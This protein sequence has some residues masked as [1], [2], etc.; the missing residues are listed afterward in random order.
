MASIVFVQREMEDKLGPMALAGYV[1]AFGH[2]ASI[3]VYPLK[4]LKRL[5]ELNP[6]LVG[7]SILSPSIDWAIATAQAIKRVLPKTPIVIGGPHPTFYPEVLQL[8]GLDIA[9]IGEGE[10]PL[11]QLLSNFDGTMESVLHT[12]NCWVKSGTTITKNEMTNLLNEEE[13][14]LLPPCD[15]SHYANYNL[16]ANN[17]HKK[18]WATRGCPLK[19][20][21]CFNSRYNAIYKGMG[22]TVR[23]RSVECIM[24]ELKQLK[25]YGWRCLEIVDDQFLLN[26]QWL[27]RFCQEYKRHI[28]LPFACN[29]TATQVKED[30]IRALK[31]AGCRTICF[32]VE[33]GSELIRRNVYSKPVTDADIYQAG[34]ILHRHRMPFLTFNMVGLPE[35]TMRDMYSTVEINQKL[36]TP[37]PWCS[38]VQPYPGTDLAD[39]LTRQGVDFRQQFSYSY[40]M[41]SPIG[42]AAQ[43]RIYSNAQKLFA[44]L[45]RA[46]VSYERFCSLVKDVPLKL[47]ALYSGVFYWNYGRQIRQRYDLNWRSLFRYWVYSKE[48]QPKFKTALPKTV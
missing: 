32:G 43:V 30:S 39:Y 48:G 21:F 38:I 17:P 22:N 31:E 42:D 16:L 3:L 47:D 19:C 10:K 24:D 44:F 37:Y 13:L 18:I 46:K 1:K 29:T 6:T 26:R 5:K 45:V 2:Q 40:F 9:C 4:N 11:L 25:V 36:R 20:T 27:E 12:P 23:R 7:M 35:E 41:T 8:D 14:S 28:D 34:E 33:S 15:R